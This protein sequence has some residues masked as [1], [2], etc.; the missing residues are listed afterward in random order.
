MRRA[1][2]TVSIDGADVTGRMEP[3]VQEI[4]VRDSAGSTS[5][6]AEVTLDDRNGQIV[7]PRSG[8]KISIALG[9][10]D[11]SPL[12]TFEGV[13]DDPLSTGSRGGGMLLQIS[14][15]SAD[16]E[17]DLKV[18]QEKHK[19][20]ATLEDAAKHFAPS[21]VSVVVAGDLAQ[22][23]RDYWAMGRENFMSWGA[24]T[25]REIGATF[26][27]MGGRAVFVPR[28][29]GLSASGKALQTIKATR[30]GNIVTWSLSPG[31]ARPDREKFEVTY[32]DPKAAK[33]KTQRGEASGIGAPKAGT[34]RFAE[35]DQDAAKGRADS[36]EKETDRDRGGG[37]VLLDGEPAALAEADCIVS[38]VRDGIDGTYRIESAEHRIQRG[39]GYQTTLELKQPQG[40]AGEDDRSAG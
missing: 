29:A 31:L 5:D 18:R 28:N 21:G 14:A 4:V 22:V 8:A 9:W 38:G 25:A 17:G 20:D 35:A 40:G 7:L 37:S 2:F 34:F 26:K 19:D 39:Q 23:R 32:Y 3:L 12:V 33:W 27:V 10:S 13:T 1:I 11:G 15:K 6:T 24:R 36:M 16:M 30:P